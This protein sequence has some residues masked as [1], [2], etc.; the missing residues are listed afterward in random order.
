MK[1]NV[2]DIV[3]EKIIRGLEKGVIPWKRS[4][5]GGFPQNLLT[6]KS[7]RGINV[8]MLSLDTFIFGFESPY[9]LTYKQA[10]RLGGSVREGEH[11]S[12]VV[13][14]KMQMKEVEKENREGEMETVNETYPVLRYYYVFNLDQCDIP[15]DK[16]PKV[17]KDLKEIKP[18]ED[19]LRNMPNPPSLRNGAGMPGYN[20]LLDKVLM[21]SL[22]KFKNSESYYGSL[23]HELTHSTGHESRC[24]RDMNNWDSESYGR[25]E[26]IAEMG[27]CFLCQVTGILESEL[28][29]STAYIKGWLGTIRKDKKALVHASSKAHKAVD[30]ILNGIKEV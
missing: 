18:C 22:D 6:Q 20:L 24:K 3:N 11:G 4:Y 26:L 8:W 19:I 12:V 25:E 30:Y 15:E 16:M 14:W 27:S 28:D 23:Y 1:K 2:Y 21:P 7:Y 13:F 29:D 17:N 10:K 5:I 9:W